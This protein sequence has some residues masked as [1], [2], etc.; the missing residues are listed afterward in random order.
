MGLSLMLADAV[1]VDLVEQ[2]GGSV[3]NRV[4]VCV[5]K[6]ACVCVPFPLRLSF[7]ASML[8]AQSFLASMLHGQLRERHGLYTTEST[9]GREYQGHDHIQPCSEGAQGK[10]TREHNLLYLKR[11]HVSVEG[12]G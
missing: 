8:H 10:R 5:I 2:H 7:L 1:I 12:N 11:K 4:C 3:L 9:Y 6:R